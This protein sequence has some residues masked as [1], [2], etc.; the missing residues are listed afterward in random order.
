MQ[1]LKLALIQTDIVWQNAEQNR[2]LY[3]KKINSIISEVD[4]IVLPEMFTTGFSLQ[5]YEIAETMQGETVQWMKQTAS[6][7]KA[8][9]CGS[10]IIL[11]EDKYFNRFLFVQPSGEIAFYNKR[12][13]FTLAGEDKVYTAGNEKVIIEYKGWKICPLICYDLRF[14]VWARNVEE[15]DVLLYVANWPKPRVAAWDTLLKARSIENLCYTIGVNRIGSDA[16]NLEYSGHSAAFNCLGEKLTNT[17]SNSACIE[18][19][20]L[21]KDHIIKTRKQFAFLSDQDYFE[22]K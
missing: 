18:I 12:H 6:E 14:P 4:F 19:V 2:I 13:L 9:I 7:A 20:S 5:P 1:D 17:V 11:E 10:V 16:N 15:Y 3:S 8:V 21:Q 22:I